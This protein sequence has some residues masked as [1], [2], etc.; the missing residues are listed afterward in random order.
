MI[1]FEDLKDIRKAIADFQEAKLVLDAVKAA[2]V[3]DFLHSGDERSAFDAA[4]DALECAAEHHVTIELALKELL[5]PKTAKEELDR[6]MAHANDHT[7][8]LGKFLDT[9]KSLAGAEFDVLRKAI[10]AHEAAQK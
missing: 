3:R 8:E 10:A 1:G 2:P 4:K 9:A 7:S 6:I 5:D